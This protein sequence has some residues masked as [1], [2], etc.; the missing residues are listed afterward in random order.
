ML[1]VSVR[2]I[3]SPSAPSCLSR[4]CDAWR[5]QVAGRLDYD[6]H[7]LLVVDRG[8][9]GSTLPASPLSV[10][11]RGPPLVLRVD[12]N[13]VDPLRLAPAIKRVITQTWK[14]PRAVTTDPAT[15]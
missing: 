10:A 2:H 5:S 14:G 1:R 9:P 6:L 3:I 7:G 12:G 8:P 15:A 4:L 13:P 11:R